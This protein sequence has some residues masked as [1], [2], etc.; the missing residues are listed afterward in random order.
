MKE[1]EGGI[2]KVRGGRE[3]GEK[4]SKGRRERRKGR[5]RKWRKSTRRR[6]RAP[7]KKSDDPDPTLSPP[8]PRVAVRGCGSRDERHVAD[9]AIT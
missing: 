1:E 5:R 4:H 6:E 3:E 8:P 7:C 9:P 2:G